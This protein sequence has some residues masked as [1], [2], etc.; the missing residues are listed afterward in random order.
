MYCAVALSGDFT[1]L[2][3]AREGD[4]A[5]QGEREKEYVGEGYSLG[6]NGHFSSFFQHIHEIPL[7]ELSW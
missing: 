7:L 5:A 6:G 4:M 2:Q 3:A 1:C